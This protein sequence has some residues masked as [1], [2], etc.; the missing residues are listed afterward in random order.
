[1]W[2]SCCKRIAL[3]IIVGSVRY[4]GIKI[5]DTRIIRLL[6][7]LLHGSNTLGGSTAKQIHEAVLAAFQLPPK[8]Y[9]LNQ[10]RYDLPKLKGTV[11][12]GVMADAMRTA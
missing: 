2:T 1:M 4:P 7:V 12:S 6:E 3:P 10:L 11:C 9:S 5:H 8:S